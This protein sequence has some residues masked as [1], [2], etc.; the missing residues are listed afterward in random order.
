MEMLIWGGTGLTL[1]G[2]LALMWCVFLAMRARRSG[3]PDEQIRAE[4]QRAVVL[5]LGALA[6]SAIGLI[7]VAVGVI[8]G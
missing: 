5:N 6:V 7:A 1:I 3:L 2:V 8:L 4:L